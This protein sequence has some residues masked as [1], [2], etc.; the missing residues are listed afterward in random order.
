MIVVSNLLMCRP[1]VSNR[2]CPLIRNMVGIFGSSIVFIG[3]LLSGSPALSSS[4]EISLFI[5]SEDNSMS[6]RAKDTVSS[7]LM[8][9]CRNNF[10]DY[11]T[12]VKKITA[13]LLQPYDGNVDRFIESQEAGQYIHAHIFAQAGGLFVNLS[14]KTERFKKGPLAVNF[15]PDWEDDL[16]TV[17]DKLSANLIRFTA[18]LSGIPPD[19]L[20]FIDC[21]K[22]D[23]SDDFP[24]VRAVTVS[25]PNHLETASLKSQKFMAHGLTHQMYIDECASQSSTNGA[26]TETSQKI[27][28]FDTVSN[29]SIRGSIR[30]STEG[31]NTKE[32]DLFIA[33]TKPPHYQQVFVS[34]VDKNS[35]LH[36]TAA[37]VADHWGKWNTNSWV[38]DQ[39]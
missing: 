18:M 31:H 37:C 21:F 30:T 36:R 11:R 22:S 29:Y 27:R 12:T 32:V 34:N 23:G 10:A 26:T 7:L 13:S 28:N 9:L 19:N 3:S 5:S 24:L 15:G 33:V 2:R 1:T 17:T 6:L 35:I 8:T 38:C 25:F 4:H 39:P 14:F 16:N 20:V